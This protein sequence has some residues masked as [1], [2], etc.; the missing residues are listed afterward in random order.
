[1]DIKTQSEASAIHALHQPIPSIFH[2]MSSPPSLKD[3]PS[4]LSHLPTHKS[5]DAPRVGLKAQIEDRMPKI[6]VGIQRDIQASFKPNTTMYM[7]ATSALHVTMTWIT[8]LISFIDQTYAELTGYSKFTSAQAWSLTTQLVVRIFSELHS[9]R[10]GVTQ[11]IH[12]AEMKNICAWVLWTSFQTH[13]KMAEFAAVN[14]ED[15]PAIASEY[16]K[17]LATNSGYEVVATLQKMVDELVA[18]KAKMMADLKAAIKKADTASAHVDDLKKLV[19]T[20]AKRMDAFKN[21]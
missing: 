20:L 5:W 19:N 12:S 10:N 7:V 15:H 21:K 3:N 14:F 17:F 9:V 4:Y 13:D 6:Y 16:V 11:N 8:S 1:L 2:D 18:D